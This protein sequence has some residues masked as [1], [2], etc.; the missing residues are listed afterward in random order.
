MEAEA[1]R[2]TYD[3]AEFA[4]RAAIREELGYGADERVCVVTVRRLV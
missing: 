3:P 2:P 4:D 1:D